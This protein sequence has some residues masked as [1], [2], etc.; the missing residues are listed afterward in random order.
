[1]S[2]TFKCVTISIGGP[3]PPADPSLTITRIYVRKNKIEVTSLNPNDNLDAYDFITTFTLINAPIP[4]LRKEFWINGKLVH[5]YED[6]NVSTGNLS[7]LVQGSS[8]RN[9]YNWITVGD[10]LRALGVT[11]TTLQ[12]C[13]KF[14][15]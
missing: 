9:Q 6:S 15:Y 5:S 7:W 14:I 10:M 1:M 11:G 2:E 4:K 8:L 12:I 3:L 13:T